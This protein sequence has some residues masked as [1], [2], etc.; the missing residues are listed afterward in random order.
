M[1]DVEWEAETVKRRDRTP[2]DVPAVSRLRE[3][4]DELWSFAVRAD[5]NHRC[6]RCGNPHSQ[7]HHLLPRRY[8]T[9]RYDLCNGI[10]LCG[11][12]HKYNADMSPH[13]NAAGFVRWL[14]EHYPARHK[15]YVETEASG[16]H[17][18]FQGT[19]NWRYYCDVI[20]GLRQHVEDYDYGRIVGVKFGAWLEENQ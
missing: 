1:A 11:P 12:C 16:E 20:R 13:Q 3:I 2:K 18:R 14:S 19:K 17:R 7:A 9:T 4:A 10:A 5:W 6:A 15:W 8:T